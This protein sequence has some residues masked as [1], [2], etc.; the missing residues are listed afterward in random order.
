MDTIHNFYID[1]INYKN[2][3]KECE[4]I[5]KDKAQGYIPK[6]FLYSTQRPKIL[7]AAKNP[8]HPLSGEI[9]YYKGKTD[10]EIIQSHM[11]FV[12]KVFNDKY[13]KTPFHKNL[14]R[15]IRFFLDLDENTDIF[16]YVVYTNLV[17]C[18][19]IKE[20]GRI[21]STTVKNCYNNFFIR[22][23]DLFKPKVIL[24]LGKEVEMFLAKKNLGIPV[25]GIKHPSYF[26]KKGDENKIL[27]EKKEKIKSFVT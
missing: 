13:L 21:K 26:Y 5:T 2:T 8:G 1:C 4:G 18:E 17:K 20:T 16:N 9:D 3:N 27:E 22:E 19:T 11:Q 24:A 6:G 23:I 12:R 15:Y 25:V 7:I 14:E 10:S